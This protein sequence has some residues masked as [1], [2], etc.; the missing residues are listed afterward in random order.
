MEKE[1]IKC[2]LVL[3]FTWVP[4][5]TI[6]YGA[7]LFSCAPNF[8]INFSILRTLL[9]KTGI[10]SVINQVDLIFSPFFPRRAADAALSHL[11][12]FPSPLPNLPFSRFNFHLFCT[13]H[14]KRRVSR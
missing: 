11:R 2:E 9:T 6:F 13:H 10:N 1:R 5:G 12:A 14:S 8:I 7:I 4:I 3:I